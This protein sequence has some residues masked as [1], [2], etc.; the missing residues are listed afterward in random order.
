MGE[1][2]RNCGAELFTGQRFCR[3]CGASTDELNQEQAP[4]QMMPPQPDDWGARSGANTAPT[5]QQNTNP[6]F[7]AP[8]GYQPSVPPMP[9]QVIPPYTPPRSRSRV[10]W[11]LAF[12]GM[13]L[14]AVVVF[15]VMMMARFG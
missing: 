4:T 13:G 15:A 7:G 10:G 11:V 1:T 2:C 6:V 12:L 9:P 3:A 8:G 14:F 5:Y